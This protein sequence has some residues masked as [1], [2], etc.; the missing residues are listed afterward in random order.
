MP[1]HEEMFT[2]AVYFGG[3]YKEDCASALQKGQ[4]WFGL[5]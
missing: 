5:Q 1:F 3:G 2:E 4:R